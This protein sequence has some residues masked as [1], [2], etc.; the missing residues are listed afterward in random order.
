MN[1]TKL[2]NWLRSE[3]QQWR[4]L[5]MQFDEADMETPGLNGDWSLKDMV[6]HLTTWHRDH[7]LCLDAAV[8]GTTAADPPWP[9]EMMDTDE[10]NAWIFSQSSQRKLEDVLEENENVFEALIGVVGSFPDDLSIEIMEGQ[11]VVRFGEQQFSVGY[12]FDHFHED[13]EAQIRKWLTQRK[14]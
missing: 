9:L 14:G 12:F 6:A 10:I 4:D 8:K 3:Q 11:P 7:V 1:K 2:I 5:L 13:H